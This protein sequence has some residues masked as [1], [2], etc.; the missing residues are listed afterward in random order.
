MYYNMKLTIDTESKINIFIAI[1]QL[2]KNCTTFI[3]LEFD[4]QQLTVQ[5]MDKSHVCLFHTII[6]KEW[7]TFYEYN[8]SSSFYSIDS[9]SFHTILSRAQENNI[10]VIKT[11]DQDTMEIELLCN[12][13]VK[14]DYNRYFQL[15]LI[16][17]DQDSFIIPDVEYDADFSLK[18]KKLHELTSQLILFGETLEITCNESG[19][20]LFS[21]GDIGKMKV[22]IPMDD[23][24]EF[25]IAEGE[26]FQLSYSLH[27]IHKMCLTTKLSK[28][29]EIS[30]SNDYP[31]RLKYDLGE[32]SYLYFF[33][34]PKIT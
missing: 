21:N 15:P 17:I 6:K 24:S 16:E 2:L 7:F 1:F 28:D 14:G 11:N 19:I 31:I 5:G 27:Y 12:E 3:R 25:S 13:T 9:V 20:D 22:T 23:L 30:I 10:I 18:T 26:T 32:E 4:T 29:I 8:E 33:V 34:A